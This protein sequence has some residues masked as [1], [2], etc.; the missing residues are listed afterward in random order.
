M[1]Y[2][3]NPEKIKQLAEGKA[4]LGHTKLPKDR[5]LLNNIA[6]GC[7]VFEYFFGDNNYYLFG[8]NKSSWDAVPIE[9]QHLPIIPLHDFLLKDELPKEDLK[10]IE[11]IGSL[12]SELKEIGSLE[13]LRFISTPDV[14][15]KLVSMLGGE[16]KQAPEDVKYV[17]CIKSAEKKDLYDFPKGHTFPAAEALQFFTNKEEFDK[18]FVY[19]TYKEHYEFWQPWKSKAEIVEPKERPRP[20]NGDGFWNI[21]AFLTSNNNVWGDENNICYDLWKVGNCFATQAEADQTADLIRWVLDNQETVLKL[22]N[23]TK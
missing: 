7:G 9:Y 11:D 10:A 1:E 13:M 22:K 23:E 4:I 16:M 8:E 14:S 19:V 3:F 18:H 15:Q 6:F 17:K 2:T 5:E 21:T 20:K 12:L